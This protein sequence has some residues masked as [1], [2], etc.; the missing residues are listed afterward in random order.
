M[1]S[2]KPHCLHS[3]SP[4]G[5][6]GGLLLGC[7]TPPRL[8]RLFDS[9]VSS[10]SRCRHSQVLMVF[11]S[12]VVVLISCVF[13]PA[14]INFLV[15]SEDISR[16][17]VSGNFETSRGTDGDGRGA[18][19]GFSAVEEV[20]PRATRVS[21]T[22]YI[23]RGGTGKMKRNFCYKVIAAFAALCLLHRLSGW[24]TRVSAGSVDRGVSK[25]GGPAVNNPHGG[26]K[27][28]KGHLWYRRQ[29]V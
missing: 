12:G 19:P 29:Y 24:P 11:G 18:L 28:D 10:I 3:T 5:L 2:A 15:P 1:T 14:W 22:E 26:R 23:T 17:T 8:V 6:P 21:T 20:A 16:F 4:L 9:E 27:W 13:F 25:D 7:Q